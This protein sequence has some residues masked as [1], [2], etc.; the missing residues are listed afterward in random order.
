M[1]G[2][3]VVLLPD[4]PLDQARPVLE[5]LRQRAGGLGISDGETEITQS[6]SIGAAEAAGNEPVPV[7]IERADA[8]LYRSKQSG[9][10][11]VELD[12]PRI[13]R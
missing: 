12:D 9:R 5:R 1:D 6:V 3:F 4:T 11:R 8:A 13:T 2:S 10:N 7:V